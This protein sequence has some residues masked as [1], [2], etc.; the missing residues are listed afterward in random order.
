MLILAEEGKVLSAIIKL[1]GVKQQSFNLWH[2]AW[3]IVKFSYSVS[4]LDLLEDGYVHKR[5]L[6]FFGSRKH[7]WTLVSFCRTLRVDLDVV[8]Y[9][10]FTR[11]ESIT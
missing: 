1:L 10:H 6:L 2:K 3:S 5:G 11:L 9:S 8:L 4:R 7:T